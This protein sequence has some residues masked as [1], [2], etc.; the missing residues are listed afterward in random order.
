MKYSAD[1]F[2][3]PR[4][5]LLV[6]FSAPALAGVQ[7]QG[8][9][10]ID[11]PERTAGDIQAAHQH[12]LANHPGPV[13]PEEP[14]FLGRAERA[15]NRSLELAEQAESAL[16]WKY[17]LRSYAAQ[18][19]DG[20]FAIEANDQ[21]QGPKPRWPG[22]VVA[23]REGKVWIH[24]SLDES[25]FPVGAEV[26]ACDGKTAKA[27]I[28]DSLFPFHGDP[29]VAGSWAV[30]TPVL[31]FD[32]GNP[33]VSPV[34]EVE[35]RLPGGKTVREELAWE[36]IA[37]VDDWYER[38]NQAVDGPRYP[39]SI[40]ELPGKVWWIR[41]SDFQPDEAGQ[42]RMNKVM[43]RIEADIESIRTSKAIILDLRRN[44]GGSSYYP[45]ELSKLLWGPEHT[46]WADSQSREQ[47]TYVEWRASHDNIATMEAY[48]PLLEQQ[49]WTEVQ[50]AGVHELIAG[51][52]EAVASGRELF[53]GPEPPEENEIEV[54]EVA[55]PI[56]A[57]IYVVISGRCASAALDA[58]DLFRRF[59][60]V[61]L[62]G[63]TTSAD[64]NYMEL[65]QHELPS[66]NATLYCPMK[67]YRNR[68]RASG[69]VYGPDIEYTGLD[70]SDR[71][72]QPWL[73]S[74]IGQA[75]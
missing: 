36:E 39:I 40:D 61:T 17:A 49:G 52:K 66:G 18:F 12:M 43:G 67:V 25:R 64:T 46:E 34:K 3:G 51:L 70:W 32:D 72:F 30:E 8:G 28:E 54:P 22:F 37:D 74:V 2:S 6:A 7:D 33:F 45:S 59:E 53:G 38:R 65:R 26:L 16:T 11:W 48:I 4:T 58:V 23:W 55:N 73:L 24:S 15:L 75:K 69:I 21:E 71:T 63:A 57:A 47:A 20:H 29:R 41:L 68:E 5:I 56:S 42:A 62:V 14:G 60:N 19:R 50:M 44:N 9:N 35:L 27:C 31:M 10:E 1:W 13:D